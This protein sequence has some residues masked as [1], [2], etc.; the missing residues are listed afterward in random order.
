MTKK[1]NPSKRKPPSP[2]SKKGRKN[3]VAAFWGT[4]AQTIYRWEKEGAPLDNTGAMI[5]WLNGRIRLPIGTKEKL[6]ELSGLDNVETN[7][8]GH[9]RIKRETVGGGVDG[10]P[11]TRELDDFLVAY[12]RNLATSMD[13]G[14]M[15]E[16]K[17]WGEEVRKTTQVINQAK[18]A[19]MKLGIQDGNLY[20]DVQI[21]EFIRS[22]VFKLNLWKQRVRDEVSPQVLAKA[23][24]LK[25]AV[26]MVDAA[27]IRAILLD[28][29]ID[30]MF[31]A[32][33]ADL[34]KTVLVSFADSFDDVVENGTE[35]IEEEYGKRK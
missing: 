35:I 27:L 3:E 18:L 14:K 8:G 9:Q 7:E 29:I 23:H 5:D 26:E 2:G 30:G 13:Q 6:R 10:D 21:D 17:F 4:Q 16:A 11:D 20:T 28:P 24:T 19:A 22:L 12:K 25:E 34:P 31:A 1:R 32:G 33:K 15:A